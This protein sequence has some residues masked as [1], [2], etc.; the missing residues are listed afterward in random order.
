MSVV[1]DAVTAL[2]ADPGAHPV[3]RALLTP[4][5][6]LY[7]AGEGLAAAAW[8]SGLRRV[9]APMLP[10]VSVG[11][12]TV[13]GT[14]KTPVS[15][16][17][18]GWFLA[19]GA[20]PAIVLRGYGNDEPEVHRQLQPDAVVV[21]SP[22]RVAGV[23]EAAARG[24]TVAVLDDG[25]QHRALARDVDLVLVS[26]ERLLRERDGHGQWRPQLLPAGPYR[27]P[28]ARLRRAHAVLLTSKTADAHD[29]AI[30]HAAVAA[31]APECPRVAIALEPGPLV[32]IAGTAAAAAVLAPG[33]RVLAIAGIGA[34]DLFA[35]QL[36]TTGATVTLRA[37]ADHHAFSDRDVAALA[38]ESAAHALVV[39]T[40]K[41]AVKLA[42]RW[43]REARALSYLSQQC[44]LTEGRERLEA[45][46]APLVA[47]RP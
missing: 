6:W 4:A 3:M 18:A 47:F 14:G 40:L 26:V 37:F 46:L 38:R 36:E 11:N 16:W 17:L 15:S 39:C 43:P 34:P 22:E 33:V 27:E 2:W 41:D 1:R 7:A 19:R 30:A 10:T 24:A 45:L 44:V 31:V 29:R 8:S 23:R 20:R 25:F 12:L 5:S 28:V 42:P 13:G 21:A 35:R 9:H 32:S